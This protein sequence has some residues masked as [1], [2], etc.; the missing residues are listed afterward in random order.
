MAGCSGGDA[1]T[2]VVGDDVEAAFQAEGIRLIASRLFHEDPNLDM[3][4]A[5]TALDAS[6][7]EMLFVNVFKSVEVARYADEHKD[8][9][10]PGIGEIMRTKNVVVYLSPKIPEGKEEAARRALSKL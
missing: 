3:T 1:P 5:Y 9:P 6:D 10:P 4:A 8:P 7:Q 2:V